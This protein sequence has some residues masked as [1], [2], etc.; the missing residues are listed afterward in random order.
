MRVK[1]ISDYLQVYKIGGFFYA[2]KYLGEDPFE[3]KRFLGSGNYMPPEVYKE[4]SKLGPSLDMW[5]LGVLLYN[6]LN[7]EFP[8]STSIHI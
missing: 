2:K 6:M 8:F 4:N 1:Y 5:S 7:D 3:E